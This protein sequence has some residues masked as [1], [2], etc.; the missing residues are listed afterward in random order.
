MFG[1][2]LCGKGNCVS[3]PAC[4]AEGGRRTTMSFARPAARGLAGVLFFDV[5]VS[6]SPSLLA[7]GHDTAEVDVL[8][9]R[10]RAQL[11]SGPPASSPA[12]AVG[13]LLALQAQNLVAARRGGTSNI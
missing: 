12:E 4:S 3:Y 7:R 11:L 5:V 1:D 6:W 13:H 8:A 10:L 2:T 9:E